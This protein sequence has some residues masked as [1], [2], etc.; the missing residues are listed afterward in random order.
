MRGLTADEVFVLAAARG[1]RLPDRLDSIVE[2]IAKR[3]LV[4]TEKIKHALVVRNTPAGDEAL[5][6][7]RAVR[8]L[9]GLV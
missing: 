7:H 4:K 1:V 9:E 2:A 5:R 3:G 6:I 8:A